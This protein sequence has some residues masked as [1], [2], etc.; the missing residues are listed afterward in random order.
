MASSTHQGFLFP[1]EEGSDLA[2]GI[3]VVNGCCRIETRGGYRVVSARGLVLAHYPVGDRMGEAYARVNLVEQGLALQTEVARTVRKLKRFE[4][5]GLTA[6][7]RY[8]PDF[9]HGKLPASSPPSVP[10]YETA[11]ARLSKVG[12]ES[13]QEVRGEPPL[14]TVADKASCLRVVD[15]GDEHAT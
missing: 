14:P 6:G 11:Q 1:A 15:S 9:G 3:V 10:R 12:E 5:K 7:P 13:L 8:Q 2:D 4:N